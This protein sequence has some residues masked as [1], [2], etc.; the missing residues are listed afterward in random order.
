MK[1]LYL[2]L[3]FFILLSVS[4]NAQQITIYDYIKL[5]A[6]NPRLYVI[7]PGTDATESE[8]SSVSEL[9]AALDVRK[10]YKENEIGS[11]SNNLIIVGSTKTNKKIKYMDM[12]ALV[13]IHGTN[14]IISGS[15]SEIKKAVRILSDYEGNRAILSSNRLEHTGEL[16]SPIMGFFTFMNVIY[17]VAAISLLVVITISVTKRLKKPSTN[18]PQLLDYVQRAIIKGYTKYQIGQSLMRAGWQKN[19][20]DEV[21]KRIP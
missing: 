14:L 18:Y 19:V 21:F 4:I 20:L 5:L 3:V 17:I 8:L 12:G 13:S 6:R 7:V 9:S 16:L 1:K 2:Y 15:S 10:I 11:L